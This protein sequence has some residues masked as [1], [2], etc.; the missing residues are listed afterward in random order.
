MSE[1]LG[2]FL[3][4]ERIKNKDEMQKGLKQ[5]YI[6]DMGELFALKYL[7]N[8]FEKNNIRNYDITP[9]D[10]DKED[11]DLEIYING[12][13]YKIEVKFS[14]IEDYPVFSK[15]HFKNNFDYLLLI[16]KSPNDKIYLAILSKKEAREIATP[17]NTDREDEDNWKIHTIDIFDENN[18]NFLKR[19]AMLLEINEELED[20]ED[21]KKLDLIE[22]AKEE[23]MK[24]PDAVK[25]DF[26][27]EVYQQWTFDYLSNYTDDVKLME[28]RDEYD[29]EYKGKHIEVKYS[30]FIEKDFHFQFWQIKPEDFDYILFVGFDKKENKFYF[31]IKRNDEVVEI[32]KE[33]SG[34]DDFYSQ[35][36]FTLGVGKH[37]ILNFVNEFYFEDF[38]NY[39]NAH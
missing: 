30:A 38:D 28:K 19:L 6:G 37:S 5:K 36:G 24:N 32:K 16:W 1:N 25:N 26:S 4:K 10:Y 8:L 17:I 14:T 18:E 31:S 12:R 3:L 15:I 33:T 9:H 20:L 35:D 11:F 13:R 7:E 23:I 2:D 21:D 29:I 27:G 39:I 22:K 34:T